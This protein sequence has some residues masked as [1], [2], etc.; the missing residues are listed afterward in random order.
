M[1]DLND[2]MDRMVAEAPPLT[3][4]ARNLISACFSGVDL[5]VDEAVDDAPAHENRQHGRPT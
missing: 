1:A 5:G 3:A 4:Q 2:W